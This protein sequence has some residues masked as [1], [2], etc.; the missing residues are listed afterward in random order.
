MTS[1]SFYFGYGASTTA[2]SLG[3]ADT[4]EHLFTGIAGASTAEGFIDGVSGGSVASTSGYSL[5]T[6]GIGSVNTTTFWYGSIKEIIIYNSDQSDNR[7]AIEANIGETPAANDTVNGFVQTWYDQSGNVPANDAVQ[8]TAANQPK[9]VDAGSLVKTTSNLPAI[10][11]TSSFTGLT[12]SR[13]ITGQSNAFFSVYEAEAGDST[14]SQVIFRQG[15]SY[16]IACEVIP[17]GRVSSSLRDGGGDSVSAS[18]GGDLATGVPLLQSVFIGAR[19][20]NGLTNFVNGAN[21]VNV[22]TSAI[23]DVDFSSVDTGSFGIGAIPNNSA[24]DM[25]GSIQELIIYNSDQSSNRPAIEANIANQYG[26]TL[27]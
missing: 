6:G 9:I 20:V 24:Y 10:D 18:S 8:T 27:S 19:G 25:H 2:V 13:F 12:A 16:R 3:S 4:S 22:N 23:E 1:G 26:I 5:Q 11:F 21:E 7:T 15:S 14:Q 17:N